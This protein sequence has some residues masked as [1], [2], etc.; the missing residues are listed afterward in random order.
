MGE[1]EDVRGPVHL[2]GGQVYGVNPPVIGQKQLISQ[3]TGTF[4]SCKVAKMH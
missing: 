3:G 4:S 2:A 1:G